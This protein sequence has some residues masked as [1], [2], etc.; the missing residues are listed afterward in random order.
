MSRFTT[1][2][3]KTSAFVI[4]LVLMLVVYAFTLVILFQLSFD[5]FNGKDLL[6]ADAENARE[7]YTF[8][9]LLVVSFIL[10]WLLLRKRWQYAAAGLALPAF[11][12]FALLSGLGPRYFTQFRSMDFDPV[13]WQQG[14][15]RPLLMARTL[16]KD[17]VLIGKTKAEVE[18]MLG[19]GWNSEMVD[20]DNILIWTVTKT[21]HLRVIFVNDK[22]IRAYIWMPGMWY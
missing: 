7:F 11:L 2:L 18:Q 8:A 19:P 21:W 14:E 9:A 17:D 5:G 22:A 20:D 16:V 13:V 12:G 15:P 1:I 3:R 4:C 6:E 10:V